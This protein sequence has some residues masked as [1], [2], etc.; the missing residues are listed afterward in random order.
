MPCIMGKVMAGVVA[1]FGIR[2]AFAEKAVKES[3]V[4]DIPL[5]NK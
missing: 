3:V 2:L 1:P 4:K 5:I